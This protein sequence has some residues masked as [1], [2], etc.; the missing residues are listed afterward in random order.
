MTVFSCSSAVPMHAPHSTTPIPHTQAWIRPSYV[1]CAAP[2]ISKWHSNS[3]T[4]SVSKHTLIHIRCI[5]H[6]PHRGRLMQ[7]LKPCALIQPVL[8]PCTSSTH[9]EPLQRLPHSS[10]LPGSVCLPICLSSDH[11]LLLPPPSLCFH[12]L[13][14]E[15]ITWNF[16][17]FFKFFTH[18]VL[19]D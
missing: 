14:P 7:V 3:P 17:F 9:S 1:A 8:I 12:T 6:L 15:K 2:G 19:A 13:L 11:S 4:C 18:S 5:L 10:P 16:Q